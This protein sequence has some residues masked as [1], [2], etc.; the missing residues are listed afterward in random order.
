MFF[1][2]LCCQQAYSALGLR[3]FFTS[4]VT[5]TR[6]WTVQ[7]GSTAPQAAGTIHTDMEKGFIRAETINYTTLVEAGSLKAAREQGLMRS[8]GK[9]YVVQEG[10]V[11]EFRFHV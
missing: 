1:D 3:T 2:T 8:E 4:G 10:D 6:A 5:E 11:L 7:G 9:E